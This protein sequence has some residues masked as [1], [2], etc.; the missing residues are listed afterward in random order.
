M[1]HASA[2]AVLGLQPLPHLEKRSQKTSLSSFPYPSLGLFIRSPTEG[3]Y[4]EIVTATQSHLVW[5][6]VSRRCSVLKA[7]FLAH[8][9][10]RNHSDF[11]IFFFSFLF[12]EED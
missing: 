1:C 8:I 12:L 4:L 5:L 2:N 9:L 6:E 7:S 11:Q 10:L 3:S